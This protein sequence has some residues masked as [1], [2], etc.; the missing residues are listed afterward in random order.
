MKPFWRP[1]YHSGKHC[2]CLSSCLRVL[3][4]ALLKVILDKIL[5]NGFAHSS[6][7]GELIETHMWH[8]CLMI[9]AMRLCSRHLT[10]ISGNI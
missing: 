3:I 8:D 10:V 4:R 5:W 2:K 6:D 1:E 9:F 7:P